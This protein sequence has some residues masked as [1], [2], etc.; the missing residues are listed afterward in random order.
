V[1]KFA[2]VRVQHIVFEEIA[3]ATVPSGVV[4]WPV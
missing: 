4:A 3:H 2:A 1:P